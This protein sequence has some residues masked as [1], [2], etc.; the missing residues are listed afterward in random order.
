[1]LIGT[2]TLIS[3]PLLLGISAGLTA[4]AV[5][6]LSFLVLEKRIN[7]R[8]FVETDGAPNMHSA[9]FAALTVGVAQYSGLPSLEFAV[10]GCFSALVTVDMWN[11]KRAASRQAEV[12]DILLSRLRPQGPVPERRPLSYSV[13]DVLTGTVLGVAVGLIV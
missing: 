9:A 1:M 2:H 5:K 7:F 12:V 8:R 6:V 3:R 11:V 13:L 10:T 4:Q